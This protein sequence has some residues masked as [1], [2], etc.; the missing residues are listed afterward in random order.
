MGSSEYLTRSGVP[1]S[2]GSAISN[3]VRSSSSDFYNR[4]MLICI[5]TIREEES[6]FSTSLAFIFLSTT[7]WIPIFCLGNTINFIA[8]RIVT[9]LVTG[10]SFLWPAASL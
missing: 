4:Y 6:T 7:S 10:K 2:Y 1:E 9:A 5:P 8:A 3:L